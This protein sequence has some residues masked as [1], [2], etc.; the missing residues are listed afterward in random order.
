MEKNRH[1]KSPVAV[2]AI[3]LSMFL[4]LP[5]S[6][7]AGS[8]DIV[9][10]DAW[11]RASIGKNRPGAVYM[12]VLNT[13]TD[14]VTL[15]GLETPLAMMLDIH[16][17]TTNVNG[18][19]SMAPAGEITIAPGETLSLEPGGLHAMLM[20]LQTPM[21]EG[22]SFSMTLTFDDGGT[23]SVEV[24]ILGRAARGPEG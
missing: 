11:A 8:Q 19:S 2:L 21:V 23:V 7:F 3:A 12:T 5:S 6:S 10:E 22:E 20:Q 18:V 16:R 4:G 9:V 17:T 13:G 1:V 15:L 24:P 14:P